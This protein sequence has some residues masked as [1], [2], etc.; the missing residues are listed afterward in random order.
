MWG[1]DFDVIFWWVRWKVDGFYYL[2]YLFI[3]FKLFERESK[4]DVFDGN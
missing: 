4:G 2:F 3:Y 1:Y